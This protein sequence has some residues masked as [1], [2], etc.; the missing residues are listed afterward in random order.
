[1]ELINLNA[2]SEIFKSHTSH[3]ATCNAYFTSF[4]GS[5]ADDRTPQILVTCPEYKKFSQDRK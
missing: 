1:M 5:N 3:L 4:K 2:I